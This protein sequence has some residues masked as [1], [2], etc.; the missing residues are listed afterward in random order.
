MCRVFQGQSGIFFLCLS[1]FTIYNCTL[2]LQLPWLPF[3]K[4]RLHFFC[5]LFPR[6]WT[7]ELFKQKMRLLRVH[8][9][10]GRLEAAAAMAPASGVWLE[11]MQACMHTHTHQQGHWS[12]AATTRGPALPCTAT[13]AETSAIFLQFQQPRSS[14]EKRIFSPFFAF[15]KPLYSAWRRLY[16]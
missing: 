1:L 3:C 12:T 14:T 11:D 2:F 9:H 15:I 16:F 8:T 5:F 6:A 4:D 10:R 13:K 7:G